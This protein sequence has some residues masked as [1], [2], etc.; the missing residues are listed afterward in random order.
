MKL[1][2]KQERL[3]IIPLDPELLHPP[4]QV[5]YLIICPETHLLCQPGKKLKLSIKFTFL[6]K[7]S[8]QTE[9]RTKICKDRRTDGGTE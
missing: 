2:N 1:D 6:T 4:I 5:L 3:N 9:L 7:H 8:W